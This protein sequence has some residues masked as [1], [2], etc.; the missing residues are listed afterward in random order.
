V[1]NSLLIEWLNDVCAHEL[2][3][4]AD[5][6][7]IE[8]RQN[9]WTFSIDVNRAAQ[10]VRDDVEH[11]V[12]EI[13]AAWRQQLRERGAAPMLFYCWHDGQA[14]QLRISAVSRSHGQLP[15]GCQ[16]EQV[17]ELSVVLNDWL[18]SPDLD[19][20]PRVELE[21]AGSERDPVSDSPLPIWAAELA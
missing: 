10:M 20:I 9:L 18:R 8:A 13:V 7:N 11:F 4:A 6:V 1:R 3:V 2:V 16:L 21:S 14:G 17:A 5:N 15:F 12:L 19:G